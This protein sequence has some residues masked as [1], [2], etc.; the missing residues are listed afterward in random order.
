MNKSP[1]YRLRTLGL[2]RPNPNHLGKE[3]TKKTRNVKAKINAKKK[4]LITQKERNKSKNNKKTQ[5][6]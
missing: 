1:I 5:N 2:I 3:S 4:I 6:N